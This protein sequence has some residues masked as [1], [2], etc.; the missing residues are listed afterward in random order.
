MKLFVLDFL[1]FKKLLKGYLKKRS[2]I[3]RRQT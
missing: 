2:R 3:Y 1:E